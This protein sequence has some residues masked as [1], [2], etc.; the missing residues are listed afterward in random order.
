MLRKIFRPRRDEVRG[1]RKRVNYEELYDLYFS[2]NIRVTKS[3]RMK[4]AGHVARI[5]E[6]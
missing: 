5:E 1:E 2:P 6:R 3:R 4:W